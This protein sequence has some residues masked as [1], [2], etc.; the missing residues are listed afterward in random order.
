MADWLEQNEN[1][2]TPYSCYLSEY[3]N[4][5][6]EARDIRNGTYG[7]SKSNDP[8]MSY[9]TYTKKFEG[10]EYGRSSV[11]YEVSISKSKTCERVKVGTRHVD[12]VPEHDEDVYEWKCESD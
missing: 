2:P 1:V 11:A 3:V 12:A 9:I 8:A 4:T 7:W 5:L 10:D 6:Q